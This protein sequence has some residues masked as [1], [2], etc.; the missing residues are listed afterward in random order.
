MPFQGIAHRFKVIKPYLYSTRLCTES[1]RAEEY[2]EDTV[3]LEPVHGRPIMVD[4][5]SKP[6]EMHNQVYCTICMFDVNEGGVGRYHVLT[7]SARTA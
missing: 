7:L 3:Q 2:L 1:A 6:T 5:I 4:L